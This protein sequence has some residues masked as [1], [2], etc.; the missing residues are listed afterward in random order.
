M[1]LFV[2]MVMVVLA[3]GDGYDGDGYYG[4]VGTGGHDIPDVW[5]ITAGSLEK[6]CLFYLVLLQLL[7][8]LLMLLET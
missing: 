6:E 7:L 5:Y 2:V 4:D 3:I 8:I 1:V